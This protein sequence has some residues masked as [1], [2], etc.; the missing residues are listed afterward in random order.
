MNKKESQTNENQTMNEEPHPEIA[1]IDHNGNLEP[2]EK[3]MTIFSA[4]NHQ[5]RAEGTA[6]AVWPEWELV[7]TSMED[8]LQIV[9][10]RRDTPEVIAERE[11][12]LNVMQFIHD[13]DAVT[14]DEYT[15][16]VDG[17]HG[18]QFTFDM[19]LEYEYW[20]S[21]RSLVEHYQ[22]TNIGPPWRENTL[23]Y[24]SR[25]EIEHSLEAYWECPE[26]VPKYGGQ[27]TRFTQENR[28][29]IDKEDSDIFPLAL[30][31]LIQ[32]CIDD[33]EMWSMMFEQDMRDIEH[34]EF[35]ETEWPGGRPDQDWEYQ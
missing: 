5:H 28:F 34:H 4:Y 31:T 9:D 6:W 10:A 29:C 8:D 33:T 15:V 7:L 21:P 14:L 16:I 12:W 13:S 35:M 2:I 26:H 3:L 23:L 20:V 17:K 19:C 22:K 24:F 25:H 32:L 27:P 1:A 18:H 30:Q 11:H